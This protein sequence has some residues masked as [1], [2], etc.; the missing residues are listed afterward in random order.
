MDTG[1]VL[2]VPALRPAL[3]VHVPAAESRQA[4]AA[5]DGARVVT[6]EHNL[7]LSLATRFHLDDN[8]DDDIDDDEDDIDEDDDEDDEGDEDDE[9]DDVETWQVTRTVIPA[10]Q[11]LPLDFRG[12]TA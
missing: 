10:K 9:D 3:L 11:Y 12:S 2:G 4:E 7:P 6:T 8:P 5:G 1:S